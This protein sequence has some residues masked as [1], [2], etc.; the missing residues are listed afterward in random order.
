MVSTYIE[1][2]LI[3]SVS[4]IWQCSFY[5]SPKGTLIIP[6]GD[7]VVCGLGSRVIVL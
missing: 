7:C 3:A 1:N 4:N 2:V 6:I 5:Q